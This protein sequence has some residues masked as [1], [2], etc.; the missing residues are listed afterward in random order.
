MAKN[1]AVRI[2]IPSP[3]FKTITLK[4]VGITPLMMHRFSEK[5]RKQM[6]EAQTA[7]DKTKK[8]R[9]PKDY[10]AEY[11]GARYVSTSRW[12]GIPAAMFRHAMIAACRTI[13]GLPMTQAKGAFFVRGQGRDKNDGIDLV[14]IYGKPVHDKRPVRLES[15]VADLRNRPRYDY[16]YC[17]VTITYDADRLSVNDIG[18][19]F[20]RA[21]LQVGVGELR[22]QGKKSFGGDYGMWTVE[23][24]SKKAA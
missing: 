3:N 11:N 23:T 10:V 6:E 4:A 22:P 21:G 19:L 8:K 15:G 14:R 7:K 17:N 12:D 18:N 13:N 24:S 9:Q 1:E 20:S 5:S 2:E 16:W